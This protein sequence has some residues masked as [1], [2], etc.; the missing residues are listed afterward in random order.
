MCKRKLLRGNA[1]RVVQR[2]VMSNARRLLGTGKIRR[3]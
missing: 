2:K 3:C 1:T